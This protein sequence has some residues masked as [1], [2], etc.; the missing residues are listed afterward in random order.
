MFLTE[1]IPNL[2]QRFPFLDVKS[3]HL[4]LVVLPVLRHL[5]EDQNHSKE[6][7]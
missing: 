1:D 6:S 2:F 4:S 7:D 5:L 3:F